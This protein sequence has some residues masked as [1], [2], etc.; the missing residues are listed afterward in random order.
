MAVST[1]VL[2]TVKG[3]ATM[4]ANFELAVAS[5]TS[6]AGLVGFI[7]AEVELIVAIPAS[8][9]AADSA[10]AEHI[11]VADQTVELAEVGHTAAD[12]GTTAAALKRAK[13]VVS[14]ATLVGL[15]GSP[16]RLS[17]EQNLVKRAAAIIA[18]A[19][20]KVQLALAASIAVD[21]GFTK[22]IPA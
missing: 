18:G 9:S 10:Q 21:T 4:A 3:P 2:A 15:A 20:L 17:A 1:G 16:A 8:S 5:A 11:V 13:F 12:Q 14:Q 6:A 19:I 22:A 7:A